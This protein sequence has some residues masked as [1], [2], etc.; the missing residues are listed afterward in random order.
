MPATYYKPN[1]GR[2][3]RAEYWRLGSGLRA[4]KE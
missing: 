4:A 3:T 1:G 2:V